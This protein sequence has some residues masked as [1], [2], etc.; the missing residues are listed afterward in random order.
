MASSM[1]SSLRSMSKV[2]VG[3]MRERSGARG[4]PV[5]A[6]KGAIVVLGPSQS[7]K[8]S[9]GVFGS[10]GKGFPHSCVSPFLCQVA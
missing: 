7:S 4:A 10:M 6:S 9:D 5:V 3:G 1:A 2:L 8:K